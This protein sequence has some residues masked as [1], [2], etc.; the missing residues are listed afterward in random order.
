MVDM[1]DL[2]KDEDPN[3]DEPE[4]RYSKAAERATDGI[5]EAIESLR[6]DEDRWQQMDAARST[7]AAA[8]DSSSLGESTLRILAE[9]IEHSDARLNDWNR[10]EESHIPDLD[11]TSVRLP[12]DRTNEHLEVLKDATHQQNEHLRVLA[13]HAANTAKETRHN[14]WRLW[15]LLAAAIG[16]G[17]IGAL[18][19]FNITPG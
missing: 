17:I 16:N 1:K 9:Q 2:G 5:R 4:N 12:A 14:N 8:M 3:R 10:L 15:L 19:Y 18:A 13:E 7:L 11:P 6:A